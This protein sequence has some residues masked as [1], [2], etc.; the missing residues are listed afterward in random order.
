MTNINSHQSIE[1]PPYNLIKIQIYLADVSYQVSKSSWEQHPLPA[2]K[3][4]SFQCLI[5]AWDNQLLA[6]TILHSG[7]KYFTDLRITFCCLWSCTLNILLKLNWTNFQLLLIIKFLFL[8]HFCCFGYTP[9]FSP[10]QT[11]KH[12]HCIMLPA[13]KLPQN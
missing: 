6:V 2:Y 4:H 9:P 3:A 13:L 1:I 10:T 5:K 7:W 11:H 8:F 12:T